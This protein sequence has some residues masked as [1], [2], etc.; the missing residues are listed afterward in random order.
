MYQSHWGLRE[1]PFGKGLDPRAF[2]QSPTHEEA[3]AR[4]HFLADEH[5]RLGLLMG[6]GGSGKSLLLQVFAAERCR[7]GATV[8]R[9][10]LVGMEPAEVLT[11]LAVQMGSCPDG[12][13][14]AARAW[15]AV[16]DRLAEARYQQ[17]AVVVLLDDADQASHA[18][19]PHL[20]RLAKS[21]ESPESRLTLILAGRR[22]G[23]GR[24]G[25]PLLDLAEL[26]I[27]I[28]PWAPGDTESFLAS[29]LS[30]AGRA[31][32][33]F[34][35]PAIARLHELSHG[36][37]RHVR[38]LAELALVAGAGRRLPEIDCEVIDAVYQ[39]LSLAAP[40]ATAW[41]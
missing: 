24:L 21:D 29:S 15:R 27:D 12:S 34:Q 9:L 18:V 32:P 4:L 13:E 10:N 38:R 3:L 1:S 16:E 7:R 2:Y 40:A 20:V 31:A 30:Q 26:R 23:L 6:P 5:R 22:E 41:S 14:S 11:S 39:E 17:L 8:L 35:Q 33:V 19:L 28:E 25:A 37:P 36:I